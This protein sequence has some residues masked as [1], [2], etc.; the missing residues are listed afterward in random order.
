MCCECLSVREEWPVEVVR[1]H[2]DRSLRES[3]RSGQFARVPT[4]LA[5][6]HLRR[7]RSARLLQ[8]PRATPAVVNFARHPKLSAVQSPDPLRE[9]PRMT[10]LRPAPA[11]PVGQHPPAE[12]LVT[13]PA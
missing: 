10:L 8:W 1:I 7:K 12:L 6:V 2:R 9:I 4:L 5:P 3:V 13:S 11:S